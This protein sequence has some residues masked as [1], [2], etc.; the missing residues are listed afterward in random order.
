[1]AKSNAERQAA[2][3]ERRAAEGIVQAVVWVH[4]TRVDELKRAAEEL[5]EPA[6]N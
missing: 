2:L 3:R 4:K 1:M 5:K 6:D